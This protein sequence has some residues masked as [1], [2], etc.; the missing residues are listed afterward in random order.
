VTLSVNSNY[1]IKGSSPD[2]RSMSNFK[3][4]FQLLAFNAQKIW[5]HVTPRFL[6]H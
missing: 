3:S 6:G 2:S 1:L 5:G 4:V